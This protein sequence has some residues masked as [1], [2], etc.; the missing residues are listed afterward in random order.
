MTN[1]EPR[2]GFSLVELLTVLVLLT[3]FALISARFFTATIKTT[4]EARA[5]ETAMLRFDQVVEALRRD[6]WSSRKIAEDP[7]GTEVQ[8]QVADRTVRWRMRAE[9]GDLVR[10][11][12]DR[13][14]GTP[15]RRWVDLPFT[16]QFRGEE[17][18]LVITV[19]PR[20]DSRAEQMH[21]VSQVLLLRGGRP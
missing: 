8:L 5:A 15:Q 10:Q 4:R 6:V 9:D 21:L 13:S 14:E 17:P 18:A 16:L 3:A 1:P 2:R 11:V 12:D 7:S 19:Q 20:G